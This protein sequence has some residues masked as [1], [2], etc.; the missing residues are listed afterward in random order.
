MNNQIR[1]Q[2]EQII[3][4]NK[5]DTETMNSVRSMLRAWN[6][7]QTANISFNEGAAMFK[8]AMEQTTDP[9]QKLKLKQA[10]IAVGRAD[11]VASEDVEEKTK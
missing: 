6:D 4:D 9:E 2:L 3:L 10:L 11:L 5:S 7:Q 1:A 8:A